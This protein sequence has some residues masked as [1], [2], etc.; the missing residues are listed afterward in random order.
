MKR[1]GNIARE[2]IAREKEKAKAPEIYESEKTEPNGKATKEENLN[3]ENNEELKIFISEKISKKNRAKIL[4]ELSNFFSIYETKIIDRS[5][6]AILSEKEIDKVKENTPSILLI[7]EKT[8]K[9]NPELAEKGIFDVI[10]SRDILKK[11]SFSVK[12]LIKSLKKQNSVSE[13]RIDTL[14]KVEEEIEK[15]RNSTYILLAVQICNFDSIVI[16]FGEK[17]SQRISNYTE[18]ILKDIGGEKLIGKI[19]ERK[20]VLLKKAE[21]QDY[22]SALKEAES[23]AKRIIK[24]F[25]DIQ[26]AYEKEINIPL[27]IG[28]AIYPYD[29]D[30]AEELIHLVEELIIKDTSESKIS[31]VSDEMKNRKYI[32]VK[33]LN[34]LSRAIEE[35]RLLFAF[36]P[37]YEAKTM[38]LKML[39]VL[40]RWKGE[41]INPEDILEA[42]HISGLE[43]KLIEYVFVNLCEIFQK[44]KKYDFSVNLHMRNL[45]KG[46]VYKI[47][48]ILSYY[49][50]PPTNICI[51]ISEKS[52]QDEIIEN[53]PNLIML[54]N[55]GM[56][57]AIDDF[58]SKESSIFQLREIPADI[59]KV[60]REIVKFL[61]SD[62]EE[63]RKFAESVFLM[64]KGTGKKIVVEGIEKEEE[65]K[66]SIRL[67]ADFVQGFLLSHPIGEE[68]LLSMIT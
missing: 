65:L 48:N 28:V 3:R 68:E 30:K 56:K 61:T 2:K 67:G 6:I 63:K 19:S 7:S 51:E 17:M 1:G 35:K 53:K 16:L 20:F 22:E 34:Q 9:I 60:D 33:I 8:R 5:D 66:E 12:S 59:V 24:N 32:K 49:G 39:E 21:K 64:L 29:S 36:Q 45:T 14:L 47:M 18:K 40:L 10:T 62:E 50:V 13:G 25:E 41:E 52:K 15:N 55:I 57:I 4:N 37:V 23:L 58:G 38:K 27:N 44:I 11:L 42:T 31:F 46:V 54:K 26:K 43:K